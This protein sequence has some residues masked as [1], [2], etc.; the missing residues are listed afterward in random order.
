MSADTP[1]LEVRDLSVDFRSGSSVVHALRGVSFQIQA[2]Q[3]LALLGES[4]SGKS[5]TSLSIMGLLPRGAGRITSG[6]IFF[7]GRE[8]TTMRAADLRRLRGQEIAMVFQDPLS[9]LNPVQTVGHQIDEMFRRHQ[10]ASRHV[11][12]RQTIEL[13]ARVRIPDPQR[14]ADSYPHEFSGGM[15]QRAMI[16][17]ALALGPRLLIADEPTTALDVTVQAQIVEL[18]MELRDERGM[19]LLFISHDLGVVAPLAERVAVMYAGRIIEQG[20]TRDVYDHPRHPY[21]AGLLRSLPDVHAGRTRLVPISGNPPDLRWV[22][23][24]CPFA[25]RCPYHRP[26]CDEQVPP[27]IPVGPDRVSACIRVAEISAD[28]DASVRPSVSVVAS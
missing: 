26:A 6:S 21:T 14:R 23:P 19:S 28:L 13:M 2:G 24:G 22:P 17:M 3:T 15:R 18:L 7:D 20:P 8:L 10:G 1:L 4:G 5:V 9:S 25:P 27:L 16:A 12:R 11:A